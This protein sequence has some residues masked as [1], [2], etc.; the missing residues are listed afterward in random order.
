MFLGKTDKINLF[1]RSTLVAAS[2]SPKGQILRNTL[3]S[4]CFFLGFRGA[5]KTQSNIK[6][7][8]FCKNS[9]RQKDVN[10]ICKSS[11]WYV[12]LGFKYISGF[13]MTQDTLDVSQPAF[14]CSKL[15]IETL[16]QGSCEIC[17]KLTIKTPERLLVFL[18][19]TFNM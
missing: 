11:F 7:G 5:F 9:Q 19:I 4:I 16:P 8:A 3:G 15:T 10:Y 13:V 18:L 17:S 14:A 1:Y 2:A 6:D 12:W